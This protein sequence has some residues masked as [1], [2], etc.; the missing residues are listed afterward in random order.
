MS[1]PRPP[2]AGTTGDLFER[3]AGSPCRARTR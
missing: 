3:A 1:R 2:G